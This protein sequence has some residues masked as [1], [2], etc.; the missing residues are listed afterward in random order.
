MWRKMQHFDFFLSSARL[1]HSIAESL[2]SELRKKGY[3]IWCDRDMLVGG[4]FIDQIL[5]AIRSSD[6]LLVLITENS[7][8]SDYQK[9]E[10]LEIVRISKE[11][12]RN[13][14]PIC[15]GNYDLL[16]ADPDL[17]YC[18]SY[19]QGI[20]IDPSD[21][22]WAQK[23]SSE[24]I[25]RIVKRDEKAQKYE[26][27][28]ELKKGGF[29]LES[30]EIL[31]DICDLILDEISPNDR[32]RTHHR[33]IF[34]LEQCLDSLHRLYHYIDDDYSS[35]ARNAAQK[36]LDL[37]GTIKSLMDDAVNEKSDLFE[38]CCM[39]RFIYHDREI[40]WDCADTLTRGDIRGMENHSLHKSD[41]AEKQRPY[42]E[43]YEKKIMDLSEKKSAVSDFIRDTAGFFIEPDEETPE[44]EKVV[45]K[46]TP[47]I[48]NEKLDAIAGYIREGNR[49]FEIIG[50]DEKAA[51][52]IRCLITS[53]ERLKNYCGEIGASDMMAEC[54]SRIT[55]LREKLRKLENTLDEDGEDHSVAEKGIR[56]LMGF[57]QP[58]AGNYDVF[59]SHRGYDSDIS[60]NVYRFLKS[61]MKE[62][63]YDAVSLASELSD[64]DYKNAIFQSLDK[65]K[66]FVVIISRLEELAPGY[67]KH[68]KDWM[69]TE[70]DTFHSELI[71]SRKQGGNFIIL[72]T[73]DVYEKIIQENKT[74]IDIKWRRYTLIRLSEFEDQIIQYLR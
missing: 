4:D 57:T 29:F 12:N 3:S 49:L 40:R 62:V 46:E 14:I 60:R 44:P 63:F 56:A 41:Y 31:T 61:R 66:H 19:Y 71:E 2:I 53:Y 54:I 15:M 10:I 67:K 8:R 50:E 21:E 6:M 64:T 5:D 25:N 45:R 13:V 55:D 28:M 38:I 47:K 72:V 39:I 69:Q 34:E 9:K 37:L 70:M 7:S 48:R 42:R 24:F 1:D 35:R 58:G 20:L 73:E 18:L 68:E 74:N 16:M 27:L 33:L 11:R 65:A 23:V 26:E 30:C 43:I 17:K 32:L 51:A 52:F 22:N 59:L 36:K